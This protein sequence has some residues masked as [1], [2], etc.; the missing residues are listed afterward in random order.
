MPISTLS[1]AASENG[2]DS[3]SRNDPAEVNTSS[4]PTLHLSSGNNDRNTANSGSD[5]TRRSAQAS[6]SSSN[7]DSTSDNRPWDDFSSDEFNDAD[8]PF[9]QG[10][11]VYQLVGGSEHGINELPARPGEVYSPP[12]RPNSPM[13]AEVMPSPVPE[14]LR[15]RISP[16]IAVANATLAMAGASSEAQQ[17]ITDLVDQAHVFFHNAEVHRRHAIRAEEREAMA[18]TLVA[19]RDAEIQQLQ[20]RLQN[21]QDWTPP[22]P[23]R[24]LSL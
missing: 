17:A 14:L 7:E 12:D 21:P 5:S 20:D 22:R 1:P 2:V 13:V 15:P 8:A 18:L 10:N 3:Y 4:I 11:G 23:Q 24:R 16:E 19:E 9:Y 6:A